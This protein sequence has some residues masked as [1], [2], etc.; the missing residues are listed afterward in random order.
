MPPNFDRNNSSWTE[1]RAFDG[2]IHLGYGIGVL[3]GCFMHYL[4]P[5]HCIQATPDFALPLIV[6]QLP[7]APDAERWAAR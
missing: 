7:G 4:R 1:P 5:N 6:G 2:T 3:G